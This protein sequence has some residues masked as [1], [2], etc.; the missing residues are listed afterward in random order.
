MIFLVGEI[1]GDIVGATS[2]DGTASLVA[3]TSVVA[4]TTSLVAPVLS[5]GTP[6]A[7]AC[8]A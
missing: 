6:K 4:P 1:V 8:V 7:T 5:P 3:M 2:L